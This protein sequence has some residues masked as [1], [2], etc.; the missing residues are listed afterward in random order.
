[1]LVVLKLSFNNSHCFVALNNNPLKQ[2]Q[3]EMLFIL[4]MCGL[5]GVRTLVMTDF[6]SSRIV[7][8]HTKVGE[9][10][11]TVKNVSFD[12]HRYQVKEFLGIPYAE[13]PVGDRRFRKSVP[14][15]PFTS[16]YTAFKYGSP[17][18][19]IFYRGPQSE[20]CLFLN[21][22][23]PVNTIGGLS[24]LPV[25]I[26]IHGGGFVTGSSTLYPSDNLSVFGEVIV[27]TLNYRLAH[28]GFLWTD[29]GV[30]NFGLWDQHLAIKWVADNIA[31]FGGDVSRVTIFG[32]S[33]GSTSVVYQSLYPGNKHLFQRA[34]AQSGSITSTWGYTSLNT[35]KAT[36]SKFAEEMRCSGNHSVIMTCLRNKTKDEI[37]S[38]VVKITFL[39][40]TN[41]VPT[42]DNEFVTQHP[43]QMIS[44]ANNMN[45]SLEMFYSLD[46]MIG[47]TS[48]DGAEYLPE[49]KIIMNI[50]NIENLKV[51]RDFYESYLIPRA[52]SMVL[53]DGSNITETMQKATI[54][55]Y[56]NWKNPNDDIA[57]N[58]MLIK[59]MSDASL[60]S[61]S[62]AAV[63]MHSEHSYAN[64][65][66]YKFSTRS[67]CHLYEY[68][69]WMDK[70]T[71]AQH[72][73]DLVFVFGFSEEY[74]G[75]LRSAGIPCNYTKENVETA[76]V[77]MTMWTNFAKS[78]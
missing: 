4:L 43:R 66:L 32:E 59:L 61:P 42:F 15:A 2:R 41:I 68:P 52:L 57:R 30:G 13:P 16:P 7:I 22:F 26:W 58:L 69:S 77:V 6:D 37:A 67:D 5:V 23:A 21:V 17:C 10:L 14:R 53:K 36:F 75:V 54:F 25:M 48:M 11:G 65:Y 29:E 62:V 70:P 40:Y 78:G 12:G 45:S 74:I 76:K 51:P 34:I 38:S 1:M 39:N 63:I 47:A 73:D 31:Q 8:V 28:L 19:Q 24:P 9:I 71:N 44:K 35:A 72:T 64:T 27:V 3:F 60:F 50:S 55:E 46:F 18:L 49:Y 56:T 20:D 33:A